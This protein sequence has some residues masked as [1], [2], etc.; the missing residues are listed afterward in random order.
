MIDGVPTARGPR[1]RRRA[2]GSSSGPTSTCRSSD[3]EITDDLRIRAALPT[4]RSGCSEQGAHGHRVHPPRPAQGRA[5]PDVLGRPGAGPPGRAGPGR[6]AA[7][8][9]ALRPGRDGQRPGLRGQSWS[10]A[11][12]PTSTTPSARRTG[13]T[14]R[15]SA[16]RAP[17]RRPP[18][19]CWRRRSRCSLG[20]RDDPRRPVRRHPRRLEGLRQARRHRRPARRRRRAD[21][22]R[23]HVLHV[24]RRPWATRSARRCSRRTRSTPAGSCSTAAPPIHLPSRH[25]RPRA[26]AA[27]SATRRPGARCASSAATCPTAGWASTSAPAPRPSSPTSSPRPARSSGTARWACSRTPASRPAPAPSPRRWPTAGA[28]PSS[29]AATARPRS[30]SSASP[31]AIDHV[32]TGGGASLELIEQGDLPGLEALRGAPNA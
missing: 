3:G 8:E 18:A 13:P 20:L 9:P 26:R 10:R 6:R 29:A 4:H 5:R 19:G 22:R 11:R 17:C 1:R 16:R 7:R 14:P 15:S 31:T 12:T 24:P 21:H 28:S 32:S 27:R 25:H 30:R 23:R 2:S